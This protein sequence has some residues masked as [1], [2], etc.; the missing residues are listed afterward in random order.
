MG[1]IG[2]SSSSSIVTSG[3]DEGSSKVRES[4]VTLSYPMLNKHNYNTWAIR[5]KACLRAQG[6]WDAVV[7]ESSDVRK[8]QMAMAAIFQGV[9]DETL[10][11][12]GGKETAKEAWDT[13][14]T[15][16]VGAE[17]V[18]EA[19]TQT[20]KSEFERLLMKDSEKIDDFVA[21]LMSVVNEIRVLGETIEETYVV[22]KFLRAVPRRY[23]QIVST[24][25]QFGDLKTMTID[26]VVGR[27]KAYE[28]R[29]HALDEKDDEH[30]ML[31]EARKSRGSSSG[32]SGKKSKFD[33]KKVRCYSCDDYGHFASD[34]PSK[35]TEKALLITEED[36]D[37]H[38]A[39][40]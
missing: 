38:P 40:M 35:K 9:P 36:E 2:A 37:Y 30:C 5:M 32:R 18:K 1:K 17:R 24:I 3:E 26:E 11:L 21:R 12:L 7:S 4:G 15:T 39:L 31:T 14:K 29:V 22:K 34:C 23:L 28:D 27:L 10:S 25:E 8:D 13:L 20:L 16:F 6:V 33:I 19:R